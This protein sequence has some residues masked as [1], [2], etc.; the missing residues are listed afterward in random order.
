MPDMLGAT[1]WI[2]DAVQVAATVLALVGMAQSQVPRELDRG[3][4]DQ[5]MVDTT[6]YLDPQ[7]TGTLARL[8]ETGST[9]AR[10]GR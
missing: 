8:I 6:R 4:L 5:L 1:R 7:T 2:F 10:P 9:S 3:S